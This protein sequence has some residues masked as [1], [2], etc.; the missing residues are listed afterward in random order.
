[1]KKVFSYLW[2]LTLTFL[3]THCSEQQTATTIKPALVL[4]ELKF[5][6][7]TESNEF[8]QKFLQSDAF[9]EVKLSLGNFQIEHLDLAQSP[10]SKIQGLVVKINP[11]NGMER[12]IM[13]AAAHTTAGE[14]MVALVRHQNV[15]SR[16]VNGKQVYSGTVN[17]S[18]AM[19]G[20]LNAMSI[21]DNKI[22]NFQIY[23]AS[24]R[25]QVQRCCWAC[26]SEQFNATYK[27]IRDACE[28]EWDC[29]FA[30]SFNPAC[31][32]GFL[33]QAVYTCTDCS[34]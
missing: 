24:A 8:F 16:L 22:T 3:L 9:K 33:S 29:S 25:R 32:I 2:L 10:D 17:W 23:S 4:S 11:E 7:V 21:D 20:N 14:E 19:G 27:A 28:A 15:Q 18:D 6:T 30:C 26:T 1:M 31:P 34:Q 13:V 12:D 5:S